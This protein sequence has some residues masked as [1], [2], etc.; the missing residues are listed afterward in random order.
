M[1][2]FLQSLHGLQYC[3]L[4]GFLLLVPGFKLQPA[5]II[6]HHQ[7]YPILIFRR[8]KPP[9]TGEHC[10]LLCSFVL[11]VFLKPHHDPPPSTLRASTECCPGVSAHSD[12]GLPH[13][14]HHA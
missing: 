1:L 12:P 14:S 9:G 6:K 7:S 3:Q 5:S 4:F 13:R 10:P 8:L 2:L 11:R